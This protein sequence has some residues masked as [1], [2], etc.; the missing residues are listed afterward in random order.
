MKKYIKVLKCSPR[1]VR[2]HRRYNSEY[3]KSNSDLPCCCGHSYYRHFDGYENDPHV[4][5]KYCGCNDFIPYTEVYSADGLNQFREYLLSL[6]ISSLVDELTNEHKLVNLLETI[7]HFRRGYA[8]H[9][10]YDFNIEHINNCVEWLTNNDIGVKKE[11]ECITKPKFKRHR[12]TSRNFQNKLSYVQ[13][14]N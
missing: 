4:S 8:K 3:E 13:V 9:Y 11:P 7:W 14:D 2:V 10:L 6:G 1:S 5:C 12:L